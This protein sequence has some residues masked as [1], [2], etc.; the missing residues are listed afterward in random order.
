M[1]LLLFHTF[2]IFRQVDQRDI[3]KEDVLKFKRG[4]KYSYTIT[5]IEKIIIFLKVFIVG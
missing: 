3:L 5:N 1:F 4:I 2:L